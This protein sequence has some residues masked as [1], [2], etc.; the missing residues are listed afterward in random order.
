M[1]SK[2]NRQNELIVSSLEKLG[3][4][5]LILVPSPSGKTPIEQQ[6]G[7]IREFSREYIRKH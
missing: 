7:S 1:I 2:D 5:E 6:L 4:S 3:V